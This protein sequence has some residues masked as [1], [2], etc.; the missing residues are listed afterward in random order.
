MA[1]QKTPRKPS[2]R[3]I[4]LCLLREIL[5]LVCFRTTDRGGRRLCRRLLLASDGL[6]N[7]NISRDSTQRCS[8]SIRPRIQLSKLIHQCAIMGPYTQATT[9]PFFHQLSETGLYNA[10]LP[11][12]VSLLTSSVDTHSLSTV[13]RSHL[14]FLQSSSGSLIRF[15]P[16]QTCATYPSFQ[17]ITESHT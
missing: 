5:A 13:V 1:P 15:L 6:S 9:L 11:S 8:A 12:S 10:A 7:M 3:R 16:S 4:T 17:V 2:R 14:V